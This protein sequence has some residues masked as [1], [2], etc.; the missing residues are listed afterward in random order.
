M[1]RLNAVI[2]LFDPSVEPLDD[3]NKCIHDKMQRKRYLY[4][5]N[6]ATRPLELMHSDI[7][8]FDK[9][10]NNCKYYITFIDD[11]SRYC[12]IYIQ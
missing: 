7:G 9:Q 5:E 12:W 10:S 4:A 3:C 2:G 11:Y 6:R 8:Q 1:Q